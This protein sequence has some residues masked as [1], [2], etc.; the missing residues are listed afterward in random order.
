[1]R[2]QW[3]VSPSPC[4]QSLSAPLSLEPAGLEAEVPAISPGLRPLASA[5]ES[6]APPRPAPRPPR[7]SRRAGPRSRSAPPSPM[8]AAAAALATASPA[9][10]GQA[11]D[12]PPLA[13]PAGLLLLRP[14]PR[15]LLH[16]FLLIGSKSRVYWSQQCT[17][18]TLAPVAEAPGPHSSTPSLA[19]RWRLGRPWGTEERPTSSEV[20]QLPLSTS[21]LCSSPISASLEKLSFRVPVF[22]GICNQN[23]S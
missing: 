5:F 6:S 23:A 20:Y 13:P 14:R 7:D 21:S 12:S 22:R 19:C 4:C 16:P 3:S 15:R 18:E 8:P 1:M 9:W 17:R 2:R 10:A 11:R